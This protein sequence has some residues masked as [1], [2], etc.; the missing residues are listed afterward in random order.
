MIKD[1][2]IIRIEQ[3]APFD[4]DNFKKIVSVYKNAK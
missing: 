4:Y 1:I 2:A 3:L